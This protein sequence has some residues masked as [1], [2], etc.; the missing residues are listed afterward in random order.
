MDWNAPE[1]PAEITEKRLI[2]AILDGHFPVN[3]NLPGERDL[4]EQ[5]GVT[6]PTLREAMQRLAR[7]GWLE[8]NHGKPTRVR[9]YLQEG[10][11]AVLA[12]I[13]SHHDHL[14]DNFINDL[15]NVRRLLAPAYTRL[16]IENNAGVLIPLLEKLASL[17][18]DAA[19]YAAADWDL[20][21]QLTLFSG[22]PVFTLILN[23]FKDLYPAIGEIYFR[24]PEARSSSKQ[25]YRDLLACA[26]EG[27]AARAQTLTERV[28]GDSLE[29]WRKIAKG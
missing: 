25:F 27:D 12:S 9:N 7:D 11:L 5:L 15:L 8:I 29:I 23:G 2:E 19:A 24:F 18:E 13:A 17:P 16:A 14:P 28:M 21:C 22:N 3:S 1:K 10:N 4:S 26:Q 6:R 20:H